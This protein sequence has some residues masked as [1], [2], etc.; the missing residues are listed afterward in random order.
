MCRTKRKVNNGLAGATLGG[1]I[2][3]SPVESRKDA[4]LGTRGA[5]ED[6]DGDDV[7]LF[8]VS[9]SLREFVRLQTH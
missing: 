1:D 4:R 7:G 6:L 3:D 5:L 8:K 9:V 2:V